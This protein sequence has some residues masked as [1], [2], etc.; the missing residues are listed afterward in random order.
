M[1]WHEWPNGPLAPRAR[2]MLLGHVPKATKAT[3]GASKFERRSKAS[4]AI[5]RL[6]TA[7]EAPNGVRRL[8]TSERRWSLHKQ[9]SKAIKE[10]ITKSNHQGF[11]LRSL[12]DWFW[13]MYIGLAVSE[14]FW[15]HVHRF[16][17]WL[18]LGQILY[19]HEMPYVNLFP[20]VP[21]F[22]LW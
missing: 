17:E 6:R 21:M 10:T 13:G 20:F 14:W 3:F 12:N 8:R 16:G 7:F 4:N 18:I 9:P 15:K 2:P 19:H 22:Q 5:R 11:E 1:A